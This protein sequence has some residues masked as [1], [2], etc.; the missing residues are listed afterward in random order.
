VPLCPEE[1]PAYT[2]TP[3]VDYDEY[4]PN[5]IPADQAAP[6]TEGYNYPV[7]ENP[8]VLPTPE[9]LPAYTEPPVVDYDEYD[10]DDIPAD[11]AAPEGYAYPVPENPL[12]LPGRARKAKLGFEDP[13]EEAD[14][15]IGLTHLDTDS[16][17]PG[18]YD[19]NSPDYIEEVEEDRSSM[20]TK[21]AKT[22]EPGVSL[23]G[24]G[25]VI[26]FHVPA[27]HIKMMERPRED[28]GAER[29]ADPFSRLLGGE[30]LPPV[31]RK[32]KKGGERMETENRVEVERHASPSNKVNKRLNKN[33]RF[34]NRNR[35]DK[36]KRTRSQGKNDKTVSTP[37]PRATPQTTSRRPRG[38]RRLSTGSRLTTRGRQNASV[39]A[40]LARG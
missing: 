31:L 21:K 7:P 11:Q 5:D 19:H 14:L 18:N 4:D 38:G 6:V 25:H 15:T 27:G 29:H 16:Y 30:L 2:E 17:D 35:G 3:A 37:R 13:T 23:T 33:K 1:Q 32:M 20:Q 12:E 39:R 9:E 22:S 8:L 36:N 34:K 28:F 24:P 10:P 40:W 26:S